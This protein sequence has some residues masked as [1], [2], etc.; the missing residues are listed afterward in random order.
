MALSDLNAA[1]IAAAGGAT[2]AQVALAA[3]RLS[4]GRIMVA[5]TS[6]GAG[7]RGNGPTYAGGVWDNL[8]LA[9]G[10]YT[11]ASNIAVGGSN[12]DALLASLDANLTTVRPDIVCFDAPTNDL[13]TTMTDAQRTAILQK[14]ELAILKIARAGA[15]PVFGF[16]PPRNGYSSS[17]VQLM[18]LVVELCR[19]YRVPFFDFYSPMVNYI[20]GDY[21]TGYNTDS[22]HFNNVGRERIRALYQDKFNDL[23]NAL[24]GPYLY[25]LRD[26]TGGNW[27]NLL[28]NGNF[29]YQ[30]TPGVPNNWTINTANGSS[31]TVTTDA[32]QPYTGKT[33]Q[34]SK[35]AAGQQVAIAG[36]APS[37]L[38]A[39][40]KLRVNARVKT[41]GLTS[42]STGW[43]FIIDPGNGET[44]AKFTGVA[45]NID[46]VISL[47]TQVVGVSTP[48]FQFYG[49]DVGTIDLNNVTM[50]DVTAAEAIFKP[51]NQ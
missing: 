24:P 29:L 20:T 13:L 8:I 26:L 42:A 50:W 41:T 25:P 5:G 27:W 40:R 45:A 32:V 43:S 30:S 12:L 47:D 49:Y 14:I 1:D 35:T 51:G 36:Q 15:F 22:T 4:G 39:A 11:Y 34:Y 31:Y 7:G 6:H 38:A 37:A 9:S 3:S 23:R 28:R 17:I 48:G 21:E 44:T 16:T 18:P 19:Y 46:S 10:K 33:F 2:A